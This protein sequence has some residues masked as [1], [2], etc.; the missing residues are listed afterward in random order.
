MK[1]FPDRPSGVELFDPVLIEMLDSNAGLFY[2]I[3]RGEL[4]EALH[5]RQAHHKI[6][7][8]YGRD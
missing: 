5:C 6:E 8:L 1:D 7:H 2:I 4:Y 3:D